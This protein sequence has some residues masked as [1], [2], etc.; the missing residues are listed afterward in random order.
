MSD[1]SPTILVVDDERGMRTT[2]VGSL[3][4]NGYTLL[5]SENGRDA[6]RAIEE[7]RPEIVISDLRLP[8][9]D[10]LEIL[11]ALIE[12]SPDSAFIV[13]TGYASVDSAMEALNEGAY[14]YITKPFNMDE[15]DRTV[16]NALEQQRL[17]RENRRLVESLQ[18]TN[19]ELNTEVEQRTKAEEAVQKS[20]GEMKKAYDRATVYAEELR[21]EIEQRRKA[22]AALARSEELRRLQVAQEAKEDERK[23]LA[24]ELH[25]ETMAE[26]VSVVVDLGIISK[27]GS[28][29]PPVVEEGLAEL[30]ERVRGSERNL[31]QIV[32]GIYPAV[33]TNL[34]LISGLTSHLEDLAT[35]PFESTEPLHIEIKARGLDGGRLP[36]ELEIAVYRVVQQAVTNAIQHAQ[37]SRI[38][39]ELIWEGHELTFSVTDDGI[40]FEPDKIEARPALGHFGLV[41]LKDRIDGLNGTIEIASEPSKGSSIRAA[42][43]TDDISTGTDDVKTS[44]FVLGNR[45]PVGRAR[46]R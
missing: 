18:K 41:N 12:A 44:T 23:R 42:I 45:D 27:L 34:G 1:E 29:L 3:E 40:G 7:H 8:D 15:V 6:I 46:A 35:R 14:A 21:Q 9:V 5:D 20:L 13:V 30:R 31:R 22:E 17:V 16:R 19:L 10:G 39:V 36:E 25:D 24:E 32:Q 38:D 43:P 28:Q 33:L 26:L 4:E 37:A 2:L 11:Q